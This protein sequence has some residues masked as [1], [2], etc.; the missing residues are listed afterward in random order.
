VVLTP[1]A[2]SIPSTR[3]RVSGAATIGPDTEP[4]RS[5]VA[6]VTATTAGETHQHRDHGLDGADHLVLMTGPAQVI[7]D[8]LLVRGQ[9]CAWPRSRASLADQL[10]RLLA[11]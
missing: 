4:Q 8:A 7:G 1:V 11:E 5:N 2:E 3:S 9:P 10:D 6:P